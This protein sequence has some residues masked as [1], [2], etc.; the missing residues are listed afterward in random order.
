LYEGCASRVVGRLED[1]NVI[2]FSLL[3][4]K[5]SYLYYP[6]FDTEPHPI[7]YHKME[8]HLGNLHVIYKDYT[9]DDNPPILHEKDTLV[10]PN[11]PN[12]EKF[13]KLTRQ[14]QDW[15]LLHNYKAISRWRGWLQCL[16]EHCAT[17]KGHQLHWRKDADP[18]KVK[19][20]KSQIQARK[21]QNDD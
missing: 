4:P 7:L 3:Q 20:L 5:I 19:L 6:D 14:E 18:Y 16:E 15:G 10:L 12:Y 9:T 2:Q 13:A 1:A 8:I 21:R 11:Y 17:L